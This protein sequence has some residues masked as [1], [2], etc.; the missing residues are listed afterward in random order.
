MMISSVYLDCKQKWLT[1]PKNGQSSIA[2]INRVI[3][4]INESN[5]YLYYSFTKVKNM[6]LSTILSLQSLY[7][8]SNCYKKVNGAVL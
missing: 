5:S 8:L 4:N 1:Y 3:S 2:T 6:T 7:K